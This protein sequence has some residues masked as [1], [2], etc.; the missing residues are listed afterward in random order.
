MAILNI[1]TSVRGLTTAIKD[2]GRLREI[3]SILARHGFG[4]ALMRLGLTETAGIKNVVSTTDGDNN[5]IPTARRI[6][7]AIEDLGPTFVKLGQILSTRPDLVP[8]DVIAEL[9]HLQDHVPV[10]TYED[11]K[12]MVES[13]LGESI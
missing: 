7:M 5:P 2:V 9:Q 10:L 8:A 11:V 13:E 12:R 6:R 3:L 1:V 4:E